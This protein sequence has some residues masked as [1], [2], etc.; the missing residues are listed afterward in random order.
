MYLIHVATL[1]VLTTIESGGQ[2]QKRGWIAKSCPIITIH[3][4]ELLCLCGKHCPSVVLANY[5]LVCVD[6]LVQVASCH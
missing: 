5:H 4:S 1:V 3:P 2:G 6:E